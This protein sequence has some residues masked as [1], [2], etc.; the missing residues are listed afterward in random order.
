MKNIPPFL[1]YA[2]T[3]LLSAVILSGAW[4]RTHKPQSNTINVTGLANRD[5]TSDLIVWKC[6]YS[7][8]SSSIKES[9]TALKKDAEI[10][11][12]YLL[13]KGVNPNELVFSSVNIE[14]EFRTEIHGTI[15]DQVFDGYRLVQKVT[16]ESK[17]VDRI[18]KV[19]REVT[20]LIDMD[21]ELNSMSP[22]YLYTKL[23]EL[24]IELIAKA[25][26]DGRIRAEQ[27]AKN[28]NASLGNL[29]SANLGVFQITGQNSSE[30]FSYGGT[31][32]TGSRN[33]TAS[34]TARL[35]FSV[36]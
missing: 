30:E 25:T 7:R 4:I 24:K 5:F 18:E 31:F 34:I 17:D 8:K 28:A 3:I 23:A 1:V 16:I 35:E 10:I 29:K 33:K 26:A 13:K 19:S 22:V 15:R 14:K 36:D 27:I 12:A 20:E 32:N 11:K 9:Y 2:V 21:I 6:S